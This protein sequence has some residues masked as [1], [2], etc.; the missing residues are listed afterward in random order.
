MEDKT[1]EQAAAAADMSVRSARKWADG[2]MP[3][4]SKKQRHWRTRKDPL[5]DVWESKIVPLL[6]ADVKGV[7]QATSIVAELE[8]RDST[9][10][11][12]SQVRTLQRRMREWKAK[13]GPPLEVFFPQE[14][15]P[16]L[17]GAFDF[18]HGNELGVTIQGEKYSHLI[19]EFI[20][21]SSKHTR[22]S[23]AYSETFEA[24][25][26][27]LQSA[28][29][30]I[31]GVPSVIRSDNLS[32]ATHELKRARGRTLTQRYRGLLEHY[33]TSST[34]I[35]PGKANENG[36][37][38]QR[39][40]WTKKH[41]AEELVFRGSKD[42]TST[43]SYA[44]FVQGVVDRRH[45]AKHSDAFRA[46]RLLLTPLPAIRLPDC[47]EYKVKVTRWSTLRILGR[48]YSVPSRLIGHEVQAKLYADEL[49]V[50]YA[51]ELMEHCPRIRQIDGHRIN[52]RHVVHSLLRKPGAFAKYRF[53]EDL[54]PTIHFRR[55]YD[56]MVAEYGSRSDVE[57]IRVLHLA[58]TT[59]ECT[60]DQALQVLLNARQPFGYLDVEKIAAPKEV[61]VPVIHIG[62]P[63][64]T[65][66]DE[67]LSGAA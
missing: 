66:Y 17:E 1:Q 57:Y 5:D 29:W 38:E 37:V 12:Q 54:F 36:V 62:A 60:V 2:A 31:G 4:A 44:V 22:T 56:A 30:D 3:S 50:F 28:L 58:A 42:F 33:R 26:A 59:M 49:K 11:L 52:Y 10:S 23:I 43:E 16:G 46:E 9:L 27:G 55:S 53:R 32:A 20:L 41:L 61:E 7:L 34:L 19:F 6:E 64:L 14:H 67:L 25:S 24:L 8:H 65:P 40:R 48:I 47:T 51:S 39:H 21:S 63:S 35:R 13:Q 18:T 15:P 45:N